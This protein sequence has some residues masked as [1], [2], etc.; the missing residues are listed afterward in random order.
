MTKTNV[1]EKLKDRHQ[2]EKYLENSSELTKYL[3][4]KHEPQIWD[5]NLETMNKR[6]VG[7]MS[8]V[9]EFKKPEKKKK[10]EDF[11]FGKIMEENRKN[12]ERERKDREN[13]NKGV[14]RAYRLNKKD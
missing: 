4:R 9:I 1:Y 10:S 11:D 6:E 8:D 14:K 7:K 2:L 13:A 5:Q 3:L 12:K